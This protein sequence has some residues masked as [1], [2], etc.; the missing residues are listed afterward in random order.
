MRKHLPPRFELIAV[1]SLEDLEDDEDVNLEVK[2]YLT[3]LEDEEG[4]LYDFTK[5]SPELLELL[6]YAYGYDEDLHPEEED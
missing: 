2:D 5:Y 1:A 4:L 3:Y 6:Y